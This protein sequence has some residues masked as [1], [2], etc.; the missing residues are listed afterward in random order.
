MKIS[1]FIE[2]NTLIKMQDRDGIKYDKRSNPDCG[3]IKIGRNAMVGLYD[4]YSGAGSCMEIEL[5]RNVELPIKFIRSALPDGGLYSVKEVYGMMRSAWK[6]C[7]IEITK[8]AEV[9]KD[10]ALLCV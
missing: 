10:E 4:P 6:D 3:I 5:E 7:N 2:L 8:P 1:D 9:N